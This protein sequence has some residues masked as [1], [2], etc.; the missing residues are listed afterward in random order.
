[1]SS[2]QAWAAEQDD[3]YHHEYRPLCDKMKAEWFHIDRIGEWK[4]HLER[5][6]K[7][8]AGESHKDIPSSEAAQALGA[9][10]VIMDYSN[11]KAPCPPPPPGPKPR[12]CAVK[13][14]D[15][16]L[17]WTATQTYY[18]G[19]GWVRMVEASALESMRERA[20]RAEA[21]F[22]E[23]C[24]RADTAEMERDAAEAQ[25]KH[26]KANHDS[27]VEFNRQLRERP[28][29]GDRAA[30]VIALRERA[31]RADA[32]AIWQLKQSEAY[33]KLAMEERERAAADLHRSQATEKLWLER[34]EK[35]E[36]SE[37][38]HLAQMQAIGRAAAKIATL[39]DAAEARFRELEATEAHL[40]MEN[41]G[42][43][44][45]NYDLSAKLTIALEDELRNKETCRELLG[46]VRE[47]EWAL[48][49]YGDH[50]SGKCEKEKDSELP[51]TCGFNQAL[52]PKPSEE[53]G[54]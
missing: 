36:E 32:R 26:W 33:A 31:E 9:T 54:V 2:G 3:I 22:T 27:M 19:D 45:A 14:G 44:D 43:Y 35:A 23:E 39:R 40:R 5:L 53:D 20:E 18:E 1:M 13:Y 21:K 50:D 51:C 24:G 8:D 7:Q 29:L 10:R 38:Y 11:P 46:R 17:L 4:R 6:K 52:A 12:E 34:A 41:K 49:R 37:R 15:N 16:G 48:I 28:D 42:M 47:L 30:S 25:V